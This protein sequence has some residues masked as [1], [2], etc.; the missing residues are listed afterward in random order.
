MLQSLVVVQVRTIWHA[1]SNLRYDLI[2]H[3]PKPAYV[4][5]Q[6]KAYTQ[7]GSS[8]QDRSITLV[9]LPESATNLQNWSIY[10]DLLEPTVKYTPKFKSDVRDWDV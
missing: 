2:P 1:D 5:V 7:H 9:K 8:G 4:T 6:R 3:K 10:G